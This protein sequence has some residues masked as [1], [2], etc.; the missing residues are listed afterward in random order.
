MRAIAGAGVA[1]SLLAYNALTNLRECRDHWYVARNAVAAVLLVRHARR[2]GLSWR[3]LG[4]A[5]ADAVRAWRVGRRVT[6]GVAVAVLVGTIAARGHDVGQRALGDR[7]AALTP[8][9]LAWQTLVRIPIGTAAFE[10]LAFRGVLFAIVAEA[11]GAR[12][13]VAA[14]SLVFGLWHVP[15]TLVTLRINGVDD[16]RARACASAVALTTAA[17]AAFAAARMTG[18]HLIA[19]WLPHWV[20]NAATLAAAARW[21]HRSGR[22]DGT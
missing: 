2:R 20:I 22:R 12:A 3:Q 13:A 8:R 15:P 18:G 6:G 21:Q 19:C 1:G 10:E 14:S 7:R 11:R 17:G 16:H 9:Q 5:P 4:L